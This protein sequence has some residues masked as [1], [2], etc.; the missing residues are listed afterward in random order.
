MKVE[1][2]PFRSIII[3]SFSM[4]HNQIRLT[5]YIGQYA[6]QC[7]MKNRVMES[8]MIQ[9]FSQTLSESSISSSGVGPPSGH[10]CK[11]LESSDEWQECTSGTCHWISE[12]R[13]SKTSFGSMDAFGTS[14]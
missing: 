1:V 4:N 5:G 2:G 9:G 7:K 3:A 13:M 12:A 11:V 10:A 14:K 6:L 8:H